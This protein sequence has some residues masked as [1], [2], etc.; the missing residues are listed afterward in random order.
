MSK[1]Y[2]V[3]M[4]FTITKTYRVEAD[5]PDAAVEEACSI[6]TP[7]FDIGDDVFED[8]Y[9]EEVLSVTDAQGEFV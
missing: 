6:C 1:T 9:N 3:F 8:H 2:N 4:R 7:A 5:T